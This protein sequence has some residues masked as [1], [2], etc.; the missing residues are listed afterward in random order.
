MS[1]FEIPNTIALPDAAA[2][3]FP[4]HLAWLGLFDRAGYHEVNLRQIA[5]ASGISKAPVYHYFERKDELLMR[6]HEEFI[7]L[8][9]AA[10]AGRDP[11]PPAEHLRALMADVL[12][13]MA[14]HRGHVRVFFEHVREL[15]EADQATIR[16]RRDRY[17]A[18]V[19]GVVA[20]GMATGAFRAGDPRLV[21][22]AV[23]GMCN[24]A[25]QWYRPDGDRSTREIADS[26]YDLV[27]NGL[28]RDP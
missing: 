4:F 5:E 3:Y 18:L 26:F 10:E 19:E 27:I 1:T 24:W 11:L 6:I 28:R 8:L 7:D 13:L 23:F 22:L 17:Q 20:R 16:E 2:L 9:L 12:G 14:T 15:S 21:T 25:Y